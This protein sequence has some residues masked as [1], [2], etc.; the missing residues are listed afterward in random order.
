MADVQIYGFIS[1]GVEH[2]KATGAAGNVAD[3]DQYE[4]RMR[5]ANENSRIG[6]KGSED[7]GNGL[8]AHWQVEQA[9]NVD[10]NTATNSWASRNSFIGLAGGFGDV[11]LGRHD[12][13]YKL[14]IDGVG[15]N[16]MTNTTADN[17]WGNTTWGQSC[18]MQSGEYNSASRSASVM[19]SSWSSGSASA[20][21]N[22]PLPVRCK[23]ARCAPQPSAAPMSSA[24]VRT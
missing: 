20:T 5:I 13:A 19:A 21:R 22:R 17:G 12:D 24:K 10:D 6:F 11:R 18:N 1:A 8:K 14:A 7:L 9:V 3:K 2:A 4:G 16:V 23:A 15:L